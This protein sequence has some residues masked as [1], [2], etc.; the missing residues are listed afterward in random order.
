MKKRRKRNR[1]AGCKW[2]DS[3]ERPI[4]GLASRISKKK[5]LMCPSCSGFICRVNDLGE[6]N[7]T[8]AHSKV[9][10]RS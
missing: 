7:A 3:K 9:T 4:E 10:D 5:V 2:C 6:Y 8:I 1:Y